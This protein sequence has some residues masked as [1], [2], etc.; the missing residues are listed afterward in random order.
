LVSTESLELYKVLDGESE[1]DAS[2]ELE[3]PVAAEHGAYEHLISIGLE[4]LEQH[5]GVASREMAEA[6]AH[7]YL[8]LGW[9]T[10]LPAINH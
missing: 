4:K 6:E 10:M 9:L 5:L 3:R 2:P 1:R 7:S 8:Q